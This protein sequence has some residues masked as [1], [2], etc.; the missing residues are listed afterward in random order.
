[1]SSA[2]FLS[3]DGTV[4]KPLSS[5][6]SPRIGASRVRGQA[7][8]EPGPMADDPAE[9]ARKAG[10]RGSRMVALGG[11]RMTAPLSR[12]SPRVGVGTNV[13]HRYGAQRPGETSAHPLSRAV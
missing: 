2:I 8:R 13:P 12:Q 9:Y 3:P 6:P 11:F 5:R 7:P 4:A 10:F 1:M